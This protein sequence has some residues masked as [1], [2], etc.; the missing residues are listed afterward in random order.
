MPQ[1]FSFSPTQPMD[2]P[3]P[4]PSLEGSVIGIDWPP[5][6]FGTSLSNCQP[7]PECWR[8]Y[9]SLA[10]TT[11]VTFLS[12]WVSYSPNATRYYALGRGAWCVR[13]PWPCVRPRPAGWPERKI[14]IG[15][16][17]RQCAQCAGLQL[18]TPS[19]H[20]TWNRGQTRYR[21]SAVSVNYNCNWI[22][23]PV[24]EKN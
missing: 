9:R 21:S 23:Q 5:W 12:E 6:S 2:G 14:N 15:R 24:N 7:K 8:K 22:R 16:L 1:Y 4:W 17:P 20:R 10:L 18:P 19:L 13:A 3:N 11:S